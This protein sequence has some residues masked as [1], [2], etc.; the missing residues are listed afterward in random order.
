MTARPAAAAIQPATS[1][2]T[3][4]GLSRTTRSPTSAPMRP[5]SLTSGAM[6][7]T[8]VASHEGMRLLGS[9][10]AG[11]VVG[12]VDPVRGVRSPSV[13]NRRAEPPRLLDLVFARKEGRVTEHAVEEEALVRVGGTVPGR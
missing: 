8:A 5:V 12:T 13:E 7:C 11:L 6:P 9:P 2:A 3:A 10:G 1:S 4:W